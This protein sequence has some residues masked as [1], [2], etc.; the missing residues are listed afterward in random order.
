MARDDRLYLSALA[1]LGLVA[2][3]E[4]VRPRLSPRSELERVRPIVCSNELRL[5]PERAPP[6]ES[7]KRRVQSG[8]RGK[9]FDVESAGCRRR[10]GAIALWSLGR[11]LPLARASARALA[12]IPGVGPTLSR[13]I[14]AARTRHPFRRLADLRRV[15]GIGAKRLSRL[16]RYLTLDPA[17]RA[18]KRTH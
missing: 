1:L 7:G 11:R 16:R 4:L 6:R 14:V 15:R 18:P 2:L 10:L 3:F 8:R 5:I 13:R 12:L 9:R 17:D